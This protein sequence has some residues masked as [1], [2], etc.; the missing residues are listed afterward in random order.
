MHFSAFYLGGSPTREAPETVFR[1]VVQYAQDAEELGYDSVWFAE[2]HFSNYGYIPNP[3][4][5]A[6]RVAAETSRVRVG[7][8]VLVLPFWNP[9]RVAEDIALTDH[10][11]GGRLEVGV[12]RGYQPFEFRRFGL[13]Q[14]EARERT[15]ETLAVLL[16]ALTEDSFT[17]D[18]RFYQI[19]ETT[20]FP[21]PLQ[22]PTPPLWLAAHTPESFEIG[23][24]FGLRALTTNSGRPVSVLEEGWSNHLAARARHPLAPPDFGVQ[25]QVC[26]AP[27]DAEA[28]E[29][30]PH[31]LYQLRQATNLRHGREHVVSGVSEPLPFEGEPS[32][33][34]MFE[35]RTLAGSPEAVRRK[36]QAYADVSGMTMLSCVFHG[37]EMPH[38]AAQRS[39]RLFAEEVM[40]AFR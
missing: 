15:D 10:L 24:R 25:A 38:E 11:T 7:T 29:Q 14:E 27:T 13:D 12:A 9:L 20:V 6:T 31:F 36:L 40:P 28:R 8:A 3:L 4:L 32:I 17:F 23:A 30:V 21:R 2:H 33:D 39:M 22:T 16:K 35:A 37:G 1:R 19:P 34:E 18:G 26:V 5:M